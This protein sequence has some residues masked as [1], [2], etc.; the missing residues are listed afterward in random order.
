MNEGIPNHPMDTPMNFAEQG[1]TLLRDLL[2]HDELDLARTLA[3]ATISRYRSRETSVVSG[4]VS[5]ADVTRQHPARN[6]D[7]RAEAF[8]NE[9]FIIGDILSLE[10]RFS[11]LLRK[12]EIWTNAA[13]LLGYPMGEV[14]LHM[15]N[16]TRKPAGIGP[17]IGWHRDCTNTYF[18][19]DDERTIRMLLP[20]Q[21]MSSRNGGTAV[22]SGSH[23]HMEST[24]QDL[25]AAI[26]PVVSPGSALVIDSKVLHGGT[27]NRSELDRDV[28]ILQFGVRSSPLRHRAEECLSLCGLDEVVRFAGSL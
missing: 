8:G 14:V 6:P 27:P 7:I 22:L 3:D 18:A 16:I 20:L 2:S 17:A 12:P 11:L 13:D 21:E 15:S 1:F 24:P 9:P 4:S 25:S 10:P 23:L 26:C 19:S 28:I 5:I